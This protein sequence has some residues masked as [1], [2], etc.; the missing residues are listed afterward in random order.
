MI[1]KAFP[2]IDPAATGENII[3]L[4]KER[5]LTV[6]DLQSFFGFEEPQA[7]YKWQRGESLPTVDNLYALGSLLEVP[8]E[9]IIIPR[10]TLRTI[11]EQQAGTCCSD[12]FCRPS[13]ALRKTGK[14]SALLPLLRLCASLPDI[15]PGRAALSAAEKICRLPHA[16]GPC[17]APVAESFLQK[18]MDY[19]GCVSSVFYA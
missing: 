8:L 6:R 15:R 3:R 11:K 19:G 18:R 14:A 7:I 1:N 13:G 5:G 10:N 12:L 2:V 16:A 9:E 4:R 17:G